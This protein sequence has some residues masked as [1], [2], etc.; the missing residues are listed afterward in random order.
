MKKVIV[1]LSM[2]GLLS[3]AC[4]EDARSF[5]S[6]GEMV[7][8][9]GCTGVDT[10]S[11]EHVKEAGVCRLDGQRLSLF[12]FENARQRDEWLHFGRRFSSDLITGPTW[13]VD[14]PEGKAD[15]LQRVLQ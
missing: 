1:V 4:G 6:V 9:I 8:A 15:E 5:G 12:V 14:P 7:G 3:V 2:V 11:A 13:A 10:T